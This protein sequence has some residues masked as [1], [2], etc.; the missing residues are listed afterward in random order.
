M[1]KQSTLL[2][3]IWKS[4]QKPILFFGFI[5]LAVGLGF[6]SSYTNGIL[7]KQWSG[8]VTEQVANLELEATKLTKAIELQDKQ[9]QVD[10]LLNQVENYNK[11]AQS[12]DDQIA[13][14]S[15]NLKTYYIGYLDIHK[16]N[17]T[18]I[19]SNLQIAGELQ[20]YDKWEMRIKEELENQ[21]PEFKAKI[22]QEYKLGTELITKIDDY[23]KQTTDTVLIGKLVG[24]SDYYKTIINWYSAIGWLQDNSNQVPTSDQILAQKTK[25]D[26]LTKT[27]KSTTELFSNINTG[28]VFSAELINTKNNLIKII[29][30]VNE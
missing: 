30:K 1:S 18:K 6:Y 28:S 14:K 9:I 22:T 24:V 10:N 29:K 4:Q 15:Y 11:I 12:Q 16:K 27:P 3:K 7:A 19:K 13:T 8:Q 17:F 26:D 21:K 23:T 2:N 5:I 25:L 20:K